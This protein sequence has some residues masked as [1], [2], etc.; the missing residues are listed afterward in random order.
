ML[1]QTGQA[2]EYRT[3]PHIGITCQCDDTFMFFHE[4]PPLCFA[5]PVGANLHRLPTDS[6]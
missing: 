4:I 6:R 3:F 1:V 2:I 5:V